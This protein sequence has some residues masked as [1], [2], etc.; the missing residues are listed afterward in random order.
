MKYE[1]K[2]EL[3]ALR[4]EHSWATGHPL[5]WEM[6]DTLTADTAHHSCKMPQ[7]CLETLIDYLISLSRPRTL[8]STPPTTAQPSRPQL[9]ISTVSIRARTSTRHPLSA[10]PCDLTKHDRAPNHLASEALSGPAR[11]VCIALGPPQK[12]TI[13]LLL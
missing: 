6:V 2:I 1:M 7:I 12:A 8:Q 4:M 11:L 3:M 13:S 5:T 9:L 10:A